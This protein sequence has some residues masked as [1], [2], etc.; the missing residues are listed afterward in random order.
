M[1]THKAVNGV[2]VPLSSKEIAAFE[3][4]DVQWAATQTEQTRSEAI[5]AIA[6][7]QITTMTPAEIDQWFAD[8]VTDMASIIRVLKTVCKIVAKEC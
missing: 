1:Y 8:N 5:I 3:K 2:R 7:D 4:R 6:A